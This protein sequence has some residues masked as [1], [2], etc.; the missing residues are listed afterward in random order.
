M[1]DI[2]G[3]LLEDFFAADSDSAQDYGLMRKTVAEL[4]SIIDLSEY[5]SEPIPFSVVKAA[6]SSA[7]ESAAPYSPFLNGKITFCSLTPMRS[8]PCKVIA[9]LGM[10]EDQF[11]RTIA[12]PG[13]NLNAEDLESSFRSR[14]L[15][16]R[17]LFLEALLSASDKLLFYYHGQD[18]HRRRDYLPSTAITELLEFAQ[19]ITSTPNLDKAL[20][21]EHRL[22]AFD[23]HY[24]GLPALPAEGFLR[25]PFS[26]HQPNASVA[27]SID[28]SASHANVAED[29]R[30][31]YQGLVL[32]PEEDAVANQPITVN[33]AELEKFFI[34]A[35]QAFLVKRL[36]FPPPE[37]DDDSASDFEPF[38]LDRLEKRGCPRPAQTARIR[39]FS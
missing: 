18:E 14:Q 24:F 11:P 34:N 12:I 25:Q 1:E 20:V 23:P 30:S 27:K 13:F 36:G 6:L 39:R 22:Q 33:L 7:V 9:M 10:D 19:K 28:Q 4:C 38:R 26:F 21:Q 3:R 32:P 31:S 37:W 16:D 17:Y 5:R 29:I 15:E 35:S 8:I 2:L